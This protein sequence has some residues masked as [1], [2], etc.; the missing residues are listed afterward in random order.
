MQKLRPSTSDSILTVVTRDG[1]RRPKGG[2]FDKKRR[3]WNIPVE[4]AHGNASDC[5]HFVQLQL[6]HLEE[7]TGLTTILRKSGFGSH[8]ASQVLAVK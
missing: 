8:L 1:I 5:Q 3:P 2:T 4:M 6:T 7:A